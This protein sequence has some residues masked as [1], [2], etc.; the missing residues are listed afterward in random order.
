MQ[1]RALAFPNWPM[2][3]E[4][5]LRNLTDV[6]TSNNWWRMNGSYNEAFER[7]FAEK[8]AVK[9][10]ITVT[11]GTHAI[12]LALMALEIGYGDEVIV[13]AYTFISTASPVFRLGAIPVA[14]DVDPETLCIDPAA[15]EAAI[16]PNTKAIIPVH[17]GGH[18]ANMDAIMEISQKYNLYVIEDAAH[19]HG[20]S[21]RG[22]PLGS[23]GHF[24]CFSF[25]YLKLMSCGE[26]GILIANDES[27]YQ[28]SWLLHN[29]GRVR[30]D[31]EYRHEVLGSNFRLSEFQAAVLFAQL[32]RLDEQNQTR[33]RNATLLRQLLL[34]V[35]GLKLAAHHEY[36][37]V[38]PYYMITLEYDPE[39]FGGCERIAFVDTL[40]EAGIPAYVGYSAIHNTGV[41]TKYGGK[42]AL[43]PVS[44]KL[45][46]S[47][48]WIHHR[49]LL[50]NETHLNL[51]V[52]KIMEVQNQRRKI[53]V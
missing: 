36:S 18:A 21:Y 6:L 24:A 53:H 44:E 37:T 52:H 25:Q 7:A 5:E 33:M 48:I 41:W 17:F 34:P 46:K 8:H 49:V 45:E 12:E 30:E 19:A 23:F 13:P 15:I 2:H 4:Q 16:T 39:K 3:D 28:K 35:E 51:L 10:G 27:L 32:Q 50:G 1:E 9:F 14:V 11:N 38:H 22:K 26:G 29:V 31:R 42:A 40:K 20:G 43:C 47:M